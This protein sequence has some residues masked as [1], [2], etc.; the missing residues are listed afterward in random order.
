MITVT[1]ELYNL[2]CGI[3]YYFVSGTK[4]RRNF[5]VSRPGESPVIKIQG[6]ITLIFQNTGFQEK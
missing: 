3:N 4:F 2:Y 1:Y 6:K 5:N